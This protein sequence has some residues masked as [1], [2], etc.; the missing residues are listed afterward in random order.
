MRGK[1]EQAVYR[2]NEKVPQFSSTFYERFLKDREREEGSALL[3]GCT[4]LESSI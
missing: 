2:R 3:R 1:K 4:A